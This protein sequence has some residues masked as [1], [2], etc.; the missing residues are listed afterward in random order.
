MVVKKDN[1]LIEREKAITRHFAKKPG[2]V[3]DIYEDAL[4]NL[5]VNKDYSEEL[6]VF[7]DK[8]IA[9]SFIVEGLKLVLSNDSISSKEIKWLKSVAIKNNLDYSW[10]NE[11][12]KNLNNSETT[13]CY[14]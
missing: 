5:L 6:I 9:E 4:K 14:I 7:S 1:K 13:I 12:M 11:R 8:E 2:F 10:F 3:R